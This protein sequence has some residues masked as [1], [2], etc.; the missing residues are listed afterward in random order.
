M[1]KKC[2]KCETVFTCQNESSGCWCESVRL[3]QE[4]LAHLKEHYEN[5][6]CTKCLKELEGEE[7]SLLNGFDLH[8]TD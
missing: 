6:L 5:C 2:S 8:G 4:T 7:G 3:T 1:E